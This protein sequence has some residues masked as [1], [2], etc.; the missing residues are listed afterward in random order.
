MKAIDL[1]TSSPGLPEIRIRPA[2]H[3]ACGAGRR[4]S[5]AAE[6]RQGGPMAALVSG[7][8][9]RSEEL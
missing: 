7:C 4:R 1:S 8:L 6:H 9:P 2:N 3:V 5:P